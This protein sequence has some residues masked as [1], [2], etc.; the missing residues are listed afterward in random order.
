MMSDNL[1]DEPGRTGGVEIAKPLFG[2]EGAN[3]SGPGYRTDGPYGAEGYVYQQWC[4]LPLV[5][6]RY[7]VFGSWVIAGEPHGLG[8]REDATP[9]TR[10]TSRF[11]PHFFRG[12]G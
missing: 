9:I 6:D 7:A 4:E 12:N 11:V 5:D 8:I 2:R 10:D 1:P 3:I